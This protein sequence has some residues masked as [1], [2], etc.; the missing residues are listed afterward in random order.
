MLRLLFAALSVLWLL[1]TFPE[2]SLASAS[3]A[4]TAW[5]SQ[6]MD[7]GYVTVIDDSG[8]IILQTGL[9]IHPGDHYIDEANHLYEITAVEGRLA[10]TRMLSGRAIL[11]DEP[12][13]VP[14][15]APNAPVQPIIAV[16]HTHTDECYL[17]TD[18]KATIPGKGSIMLVGDALTNRLGELGFQTIHDKTLHDPHD[19][20]A[21]QRSRRTFLKLLEQQPATLFDLHRDSAPAN[22]YQTTINEQ[23]A[24]KILLV[25][26]R[27]NQNEA[28]TLDYAKRIKTSADAKYKGLIRGIFIAHGNYNQDLNPRSMLLEIGTQYTTLQAAAHSAALFA[29]VVPS[30]LSPG[31]SPDSADTSFNAGVS[32]D[33]NPAP[34]AEMTDSEAKDATAASGFSVSTVHDLFFILAAFV[35]GTIS[36]LYLSTGSWQEA[37]AKLARFRKYEFTNFFG[38]RKKRKD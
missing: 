18:G 26:G 3:S 11:F 24:A 21:Y 16:Y 36:Y 30:F 19:A 34:P 4:A 20:N 22:I 8:I 2:I 10:K 23:P 14:A 12:M 5:K 7:E 6:E 38:S 25:V 17:P 9:T 37:K 27:Q 32:G 28:T 13:A 31:P 15:Q 1:G 35:I 29:D 33:S